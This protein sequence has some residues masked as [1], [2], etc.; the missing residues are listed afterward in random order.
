VLRDAAV[1]GES[2]QVVLLNRAPGV[3]TDYISGFQ[4]ILV[5]NFT[6]RD[7]WCAGSSDADV[8]VSHLCML[9]T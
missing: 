2:D 5:G 9:V 8:V 6:D 4:E 7:Y 1:G 3:D